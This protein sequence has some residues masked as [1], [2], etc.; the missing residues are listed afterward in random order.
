MSEQKPPIAPVVPVQTPGGAETAPPVKPNPAETVDIKA[1]IDLQKENAKLEKANAKLE[2]EKDEVERVSVLQELTHINKKLAKAKKDDDLATL[3]IVLATA[4]EL[5][6][7]FPELDPEGSKN[8]PKS[9]IAGY[10]LLGSD[11][12]LGVE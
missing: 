8:K 7:T 6:G 3:K 9:T 12:I 4:R 1:F 5:K 10:T 11:K 2:S